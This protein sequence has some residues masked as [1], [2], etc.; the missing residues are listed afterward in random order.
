MCATGSETGQA[1]RNR[2]PERFAAPV[3]R[4]GDREHARCATAGLGPLARGTAN[5]RRE[6]DLQAQHSTRPALE[7]PPVEAT[8]L[9]TQPASLRCALTFD[10]PFARAP[11]RTSARSRPRSMCPLRVPPA[12]SHGHRGDRGH[13]RCA[14][15]ALGPLARGTA[16]HRREN[17]LQAQHSTRPALEPP[18]VE[19]TSLGTQPAS[20]RCALTFDV[21]FARAPPRTCARSMCPLRVLPRAPMDTGETANTRA[22]LPRV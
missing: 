6:N 15:A 17:D 16:N 2:G 1:R 9:G 19:A 11:P 3:G 20:L 4:S 21:P 5:H 22:A 10:V 8:S 13:A 18:P 12:C 14:T 7:P